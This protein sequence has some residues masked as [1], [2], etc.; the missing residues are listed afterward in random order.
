[1]KIYFL[2]LNCIFHEQSSLKWFWY[3]SLIGAEVPWQGKQSPTKTSY[4]LY[5]GLTF[6]LRV[7]TQLVFKCWVLTEITHRMLT[8]RACW[9]IGRIKYS[10]LVVKK[11]QNTLWAQPVLFLCLQAGASITMDGVTAHGVFGVIL[12]VL[13]PGK[14][15]QSEQH[16]F[17]FLQR[18]QQLR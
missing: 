18:F 7:E 6:Y 13:L 4:C 11:S 5:D 2:I 8:D 3:C 17:L 1:M 10:L 16:R 9:Q 15:Q 14:L 12:L